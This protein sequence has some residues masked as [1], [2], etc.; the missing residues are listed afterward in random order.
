MVGLLS[1]VGLG[2]RA[3]VLEDDGVGPE[4]CARSAMRGLWV[5]VGGRAVVVGT[6]TVAGPAFLAADSLAQVSLSNTP[7]WPRW[8]NFL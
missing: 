4:A 1:L 5:W 8:E 2:D 6:A 3:V 7:S